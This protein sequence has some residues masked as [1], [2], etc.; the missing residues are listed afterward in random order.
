[1]KSIL[2]WSPHLSNVATI[3]NVIKS[4]KSIKRFS[5]F[6]NPV[7]L[8]ASGEWFDFREELEQNKIQTYKLSKLDL[9][10]YYPIEGFFKSR[11]F[12]VLIF[13][14]NFFPLLRYLKEKKP[15]FLIVH[16]VTFLPLFIFYFNKIDT[17]LIL[18]IS[19]LPKLNFLRTFFWKRISSKLYCIT[20]PSEETKKNLEKKNIFPSK[21]LVLLKD[22]I[23]DLEYVNKFKFKELKDKKVNNSY[24]LTIGR[25][26][27][28]KNH[29][30]IINTFNDIKN[31]GVNIKLVI[32]GEGEERRNLENL[33]KEFNLAN[34]IILIGYK[35][36]VF[37]YIK[38]ALAVISSSKWEDPGAVMIESAFLNTIVISSDCESGPKEFIENDKAGYLFKNNNAIDLGK[39]IKLFINDDPKEIQKKKIYAKKKTKAYSV[40]NHYKTLNY[41][42][43]S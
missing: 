41:I 10:K 13:L 11:F 8:D 23:I 20:C 29:K 28:Q 14:K 35:E 43:S 27:E 15:E 25:L 9:K 6:H 12:S 18:R 24:F 19:G 42:L 5:K 3:N 34:Q 32:I 40:F 39:K 4:A 1:M 26:T 30:L 22:P 21:K 36:N 31:Y 7:I 38:K 2:Y 16:L 33:I 37:P 17:K